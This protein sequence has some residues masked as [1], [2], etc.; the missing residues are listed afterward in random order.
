MDGNF[1]F[2]G[3]NIDTGKEAE[4]IVISRKCAVTY[5]NNHRGVVLKYKTVGKVVMK[6]TKSRI[7]KVKLNE[8]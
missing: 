7:C 5:E 8:N 2:L 3:A 4:K 6:A 1:Y